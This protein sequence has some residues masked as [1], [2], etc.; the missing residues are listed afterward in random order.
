[1]WV[2]L[3]FFLGEPVE[4]W[5]KV[6]NLLPKPWSIQLLILFVY[7]IIIIDE[8]MMY[9][10]ISASSISKKASEPIQIKS[11]ICIHENLNKNLFDRPNNPNY[12]PRS[13]T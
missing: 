12:L 10:L 2:L 6:M 5:K 3:F 11:D 4:A 1:M 13:D 7:I 8:T 9:F